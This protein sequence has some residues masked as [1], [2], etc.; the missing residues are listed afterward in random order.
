MKVKTTIIGLGQVGASIGLALADH[1]DQIVRIGHDKNL[2]T[3]KAAEKAGALDQVIINLHKAVENSDLVILAVPVDEVTDLITEIAP[4]LKDGAVLMD[5]SPLRTSF[6]SLAS[7]LLP[8]GRHFVSFTPTINPAWL[9]ETDGGLNAAHADLFRNSQI[10][11]TVPPA[12][13]ADALKLACDLA[14]LLGAQTLF[15]DPL[16]ADGLTAAVRQLPI[17][18]AAG[19]VRSV[20]NQPGWRE[21]RKL[22]G[23]A[24]FHATWPALHL[25]ETGKPGLSLLMNRDNSLRVLDN[26]ILS[27][28][29]L[30]RLLEEEDN[31]GLQTYMR[32]AQEARAVWWKDRQSGDWETSLPAPDLP[33]TGEMLGHLIGIRP[34]RDKSTHN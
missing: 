20:G 9:E 14:A 26:L 30:R 3:A 27:L 29:D 16:E 11:I 19:L 18:A 4:D 1:T 22:A 28:Q 32:S 23:K 7:S 17:M 13:E 33:T 6:C 21:A 10:V 15:S 25:D 8:A 34:K 31:E 24:F 12:T 2:K 5:T